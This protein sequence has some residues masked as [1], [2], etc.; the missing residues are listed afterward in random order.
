MIEQARPIVL[1]LSRIAIGVIF[2][3]H[4]YQKFATMGIAG[5]TE[6][7]ESVGI[8][9][10]GVAA[11]AVA[12]LEVVGGLALIAGAALPIVGSLLALNMI[13]AIV[14]VHGANGFGAGEG[15][16]E[17][18]LALAAAS[19]AVGF[20]GGGA[21]ALDRVLGRRGGAATVTA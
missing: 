12:T 16:Y 10:A 4:G 2:I 15:G 5:T 3:V 20:S 17:F 13:G 7:F 18:V 6:F 1:L 9:L 19:L 21:F 14:F 8:P 11:P